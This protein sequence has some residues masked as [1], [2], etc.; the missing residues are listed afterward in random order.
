MDWV[1]TLGLVVLM[2]VAFTAGIWTAILVPGGP[3]SADPQVEPATTPVVASTSSPGALPSAPSAYTG[4][5]LAFGDYVL[6]SVKPCLR[7]LGF[8]VDAVSDRRVDAAAFD[9]RAIDDSIPGGVLIHLGANGGATAAELDGLMKILGPDRVVVWT[10][11]Q[12]PDDPERYTFEQ[13]TNAAIAGL[14]E[15]YPNVRIFSWNA[16]SM[17]NP[18][19]LNADG[20]MT[21]DGCKAFA[22]YAEQVMRAGT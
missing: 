6:V 4:D 3:L 11:I 7:K 5:V 15:T 12:L 21:K 13:D 20:S 19:W 1:R 10:T 2:L 8:E 16:L 18:E 22:S 9:L 14:A 17:T